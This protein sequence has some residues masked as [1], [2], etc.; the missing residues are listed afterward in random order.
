MIGGLNMVKVVCSKPEAIS[1]LDKKD[2][3]RYNALKYNIFLGAYFILSNKHS[4]VL[5]HL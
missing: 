1:Q 5:Q 4:V 2:Y 3:H